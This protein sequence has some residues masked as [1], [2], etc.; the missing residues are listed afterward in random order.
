MSTTGDYYNPVYGRGYNWTQE[1]EEK[2]LEAIN[3]LIYLGMD[4]EF[5]VSNADAVFGFEIEY[6]KYGDGK[7]YASLRDPGETYGGQFVNL[8]I[9]E[10]ASQFKKDIP[11]LFNYQAPETT[12][13][14]S[15]GSNNK[16]IW[17]M[18]VQ[19]LYSEELYSDW[20]PDTEYVPM[21]SILDSNDDGRFAG[22][23]GGLINNLLGGLTPQRTALEDATQHAR[24]F[25]QYGTYYRNI[26]EQINYDIYVMQ[27]LGLFHDNSGVNHY[28]FNT[29][30]YK[31][32]P[33]TSGSGFTQAKGTYTELALNAMNSLVKVLNDYGTYVSGYGHTVDGVMTPALP[34]IVPNYY[35]PFAIPTQ[36]V[37]DKIADIDRFHRDPNARGQ[38]V[39]VGQPPDPLA[40]SHELENYYDENGVLKQRYVPDPNYIASLNH[41]NPF[42]PEEYTPEIAKT[43][44]MVLQDAENEKR[45]EYEDAASK[46]VS[47]WNR[48]V[49]YVKAYGANDNYIYNRLFTEEGQ[50]PPTYPTEDDWSTYGQASDRNMS[51]YRDYGIQ[52]RAGF[53][54]ANYGYDSASYWYD[55]AQQEIED[56]KI[57]Y[58]DWQQELA[59]AQGSG[60]LLDEYQNEYDI[61]SDDL[62]A[63]KTQLNNYLDIIEG[64]KQYGGGFNQLGAGG[65]S[66]S[67]FWR[68]NGEDYNQTIKNIAAIEA[69]RINLQQK[70]AAYQESVSFYDLGPSFFFS[71]LYVPPEGYGLNPNI[72][73]GAVDP[74]DEV[75]FDENGNPM[76]IDPNTGLPVAG[77]ESPEEKQRRLARE[78]AEQAA[79]DAAAAAAQAA[80]DLVDRQLEKATAELAYAQAFSDEFDKQNELDQ[81]EQSL[82]AAQASFDTIGNST[83]IADLATAQAALATAQ[84]NLTAA[85]AALTTAQGA[86]D[87]ASAAEA[88][89]ISAATDAVNTAS[90]AAAAA[91]EAARL[92]AEAAANDSLS[93]VQDA[94]DALVALEEAQ[95]IQAEAE[96][97]AQTELTAE[98]V[99]TLRLANL[100]LQ[101]AQKDKTDAD[102]EAARIQGLL[103]TANQNAATTA[104]NHAKALQDAEADA[105]A[106]IATAQ[107]AATKAAQEAAAITLQA[108]QA[109]AAQAALDAATAAA[110][111]QAAAVA[112]EQSNTKAAQDA[113]IA[114]NAAKVAADLAKAKADA[115]LLAKEQTLA[116][117]NADLAT[118]NADLATANSDLSTAESGLE[119]ANADLEA[120]NATIAGE[121]ARQA[122]AVAEAERL[123]RQAALTEE[124][125]AER[126]AAFQERQDVL[127]YLASGLQ[128]AEILTLYP[129][130]EYQFE[131]ETISTGFTS[132]SLNAHLAV[133]NGEESLFYATDGSVYTTAEAANSQNSFIDQQY[134]GAKS[135]YLEK[136][137]QA[138][139]NLSDILTWQESLGGVDSP[140]FRAAW[141][142]LAT[143]R[144]NFNN[145]NELSE[146][147]ETEQTITAFDPAGQEV[148]Y[149]IS[150]YRSLAEQNYYRGLESIKGLIAVAEK[151]MVDSD[152]NSAHPDAQKF[153]EYRD[154]KEQLQNLKF[155][156]IRQNGASGNQ[157]LDQNGNLV[158]TAFDL[159]TLPVVTPY[160]NFLSKDGQF[161]FT[162][163]E[164]LA[165][166]DMFDFPLRAVDP[167]TGTV[168]KFSAGET[169]Q[170]NAK[171][172][173]LDNPWIA[174]DSEGTTF[175]FPYDS[176]ANDGGESVATQ[177]QYEFDNPY[178]LQDND[179]NEYRFATLAD[180]NNWNQQYQYSLLEYTATDP[181]G[182]VFRY[183]TEA[184]ALNRQYQFDNPI[185]VYDIGGTNPAI[186]VDGREIRFPDT[187]T[188]NADALSRQN[189]INNPFLHEDGT[190][191]VTQEGML[192]HRPYYSLDGY[193]YYSVAEQNTADIAWTQTQNQINTRQTNLSNFQAN[194]DL[195]TQNMRD[196]LTAGD[197]AGYNKAL[198]E[199]NVAQNIYRAYDLQERLP[200][201]PQVLTPYTSPALG[202]ADEDITEGFDPYSFF[203]LPTTA[204]LPEGGVND[205][206]SAAG[207]VLGLSPGTEGSTEQVMIDVF[208]SVQN[209]DDMRDALETSYGFGD[210]VY[211]QPSDMTFDYIAN[212][213]EAADLAGA[214]LY[215]FV[216]DYADYNALIAKDK[217]DFDAAIE[218][219]KTATTAYRTIQGQQ[220]AVN[221]LQA[222]AEGR[223][224]A[225]LEARKAFYSEK[226]LS[227]EDIL[228]S[229]DEPEQKLYYAADGTSWVYDDDQWWEFQGERLAGYG[230]ESAYASPGFS[231][232]DEFMTRWY[233]KVDRRI[234]SIILNAGAGYYEDFSNFEEMLPGGSYTIPREVI[235]ELAKEERELLGETK[236]IVDNAVNKYNIDNAAAIAA[237]PDPYNDYTNAYSTLINLGATREAYYDVLPDGSIQIKTPQE[238]ADIGWTQ[239]TKDYGSFEEFR[240]K[241]AQEKAVLYGSVRAEDSPYS[242]SD[243]YGE[244]LSQ[245]SYNPYY[246]AFDLNKDGELDSLD[247]AFGNQVIS[248]EYR[249]WSIGNL[250]DPYGD[251]NFFDT[252]EKL[253]QYAIGI[254]WDEVR[255]RHE[256]YKRKTGDYDTSYIAYGLGEAGVET[257]FAELKGPDGNYLYSLKEGQGD[258]MIIGRTYLK[259]QASGGLDIFPDWIDNIL[260]ATSFFNPVAGATA[261]AEA[262][263][264]APQ[265][266][267]AMNY[268]AALVPYVPG[269]NQPY[270]GKHWQFK[271]PD[272]DQPRMWEQY[273]AESDWNTLNTTVTSLGADKFQPLGTTQGEYLQAAQAAPSAAQQAQL[274]TIDPYAAL[275][276]QTPAPADPYADTSNYDA[277]FANQYGTDIAAKDQLVQDQFAQYM[278]DNNI[279]NPNRRDL[280]NFEASLADQT[281]I[282][283]QNTG[284]LPTGVYS[285]LD[286]DK[287]VT[288]DDFAEMYPEG[289]TT[290]SGTVVS[291]LYGSSGAL[292]DPAQSSYEWANQ[293]GFVSPFANDDPTGNYGFD[294]ENP[295]PFYY[296]NDLLGRTPDTN[297]QTNAPFGQ[298]NY[299]DTWQINPYELSFT[300]MSQ[301]YQQTYA[302]Q[303]MDP[304]ATID[305]DN[306]DPYAALGNA[307]FD[308][309]SVNVPIDDAQ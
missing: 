150:G 209:Y 156:Y 269:E 164:R 217:E 211:I 123:A 137:T 89:A 172:Y 104:A 185:I 39:Q 3:E 277:L 93:A 54:N 84:S 78:A 280:A 303:L 195:A 284:F 224:N 34:E 58:P 23:N 139:Q 177:K 120:A 254:N 38:N 175:R 114:A 88:A 285:T 307:Q 259:L 208:G 95:R 52:L 191:F 113:L 199:L 248:E 216:N 231:Y 205:S 298:Q 158:I 309:S 250:L 222:V 173:S 154:F 278:S 41:K 111:A 302:E 33:I 239:G 117:A 281:G 273:M 86:L 294:V 192:G 71:D 18:S 263:V 233:N 135:I 270:K 184:E 283:D 110:N 165:A 167:Q 215:E 44:L 109:A 291:D 83:T 91:A 128:P 124:Q 112:A 155:N 46:R 131:G 140:A 241:K 201:V 251:I 300:G 203:N 47:T 207:F 162:D 126:L 179:G 151:G 174:I 63:E 225:S 100:A 247:V 97:A 261:L 182:T 292:I 14:Y 145:F 30:N 121:A 240:N 186:G 105:V 157:V 204:E 133:L 279:T 80:Q 2:L 64:R 249:G 230:P 229:G 210:G 61:L 73:Q 187:E 238:I 77:Y 53:T 40:I 176:N 17:R 166:D 20:Q 213:P 306:L 265:A 11:E 268:D 232:V 62:N 183:G 202:E 8:T 21:S 188:G 69:E 153:I 103:D 51:S 29:E 147:P 180:A 168:F 101:N 49:S 96:L 107:A 286:P 272:A 246:S 76:N 221:A 290:P 19:R 267:D 260:L 55:D 146:T 171:Q 50:I 129:Y 170:Y 5:A 234:P 22:R 266:I 32:S 296:R 66:M 227:Y 178:V 235:L 94:A 226:G 12:A 28:D 81:A 26:A 27:T 244:E 143:A 252:E 106:R 214:D 141:E 136:Y 200:S 125:K 98:T 212:L 134:E 115:D 85:Q 72:S 219:F 198:S 159:T 118:A 60:R 122:A 236:V 68:L 31:N 99:E 255:K 74:A 274:D 48:W 256:Y 24:K 36:D 102:S 7:H 56:Y 15:E 45:L 194:I 169:E 25:D 196:A 282:Y 308:P 57:R 127:G 10:A 132:D 258:Q 37:I 262:A 130:A 220:A 257:K 67:D 148:D 271:L 90:S 181:E 245:I 299:A 160:Y 35:I 108:E 189:E 59:N 243:N 144:T 92:T 253:Q 289:Y 4:P 43:P 288:Q 218:N 276:G 193:Y 42:T 275:Y 223:D 206:Q 82:T 79:Q 6:N 190:R 242:Y 287:R 142:E 87:S 264:N 9:K 1:E 70:M 237:A 161:Y 152:T 163:A 149:Q 228:A 304:Y 197:T 301:P 116:N 13:T 138:Q 16:N 295:L 119:T 75:T 293:Q 297:V 65:L 305:Q